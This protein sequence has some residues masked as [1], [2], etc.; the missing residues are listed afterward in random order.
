MRSITT[1]YD[2]GME[3]RVRIYLKGI[4]QPAIL[5]ADEIDDKDNAKII[6]K[7]GGKQCAEFHKSEVAGWSIHEIDDEIARE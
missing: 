6:V 7:S 1:V 5:K 3:M 2:L 4:Q